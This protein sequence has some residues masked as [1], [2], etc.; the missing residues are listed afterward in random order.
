MF[1]DLSHFDEKDLKNLMV[2]LGIISNGS[3]VDRAYR[4]ALRNII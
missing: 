3:L 2:P 1:Q 4:E